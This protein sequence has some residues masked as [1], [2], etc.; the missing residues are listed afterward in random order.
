MV[1]MAGDGIAEA[2]ERLAEGGETP[3]EAIGRLLALPHPGEAALDR[4]RDA[5]L[6]GH[7]RSVAGPAGVG[8][9][10]RALGLIAVAGALGA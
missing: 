9:Y 2:L 7:A 1:G 3:D 4:M 6:A 5:C 8:G 10:G